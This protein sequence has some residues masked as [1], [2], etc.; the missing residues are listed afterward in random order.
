MLCLF[1][2]AKEFIEALDEDKRIKAEEHETCQE[3]DLHKIQIL[4][5]KYGLVAIAHPPSVC[6][7]SLTFDALYSVV[8]EAASD[9][10]YFSSQS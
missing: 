2:W 1:R 4:T 6:I 3:R 5:E 9:P 7:I 10:T 8:S